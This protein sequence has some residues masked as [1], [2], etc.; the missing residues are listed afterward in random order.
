MPAGTKKEVYLRL[1]SIGE[2]AKKNQLAPEKVDA[3]FGV[4]PAR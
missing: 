3:F 2:I 1:V 4:V